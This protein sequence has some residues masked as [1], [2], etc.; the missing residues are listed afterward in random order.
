MA[1]ITAREWKSGNMSG[2]AACSTTEPSPQQVF[3]LRGGAK[4]DT[5]G[6]S[7][8]WTRATPRPSS[9]HA[10]PTYGQWRAHQRAREQCA[11]PGIQP[12]TVA[13]ARKPFQRPVF[14]RP[15]PAFKQPSPRQHRSPPTS[16]SQARW[17]HPRQG[18]DV[19][20]IGRPLD[21]RKL[22]KMLLEAG[23]DISERNVANILHDAHVRKDTRGPSLNAPQF[24]SELM[25]MQTVDVPVQKR[26]AASEFDLPF[27]VPYRV[28]LAFDAVDRDKSGYL[29][30][31][32]I[33][34]ALK[35]YGIDATC[36]EAAGQV[37]EA[38]G[39]DGQLDFREF[40]LLVAE[41]EEK[42]RLHRQLSHFDASLTPRQPFS[43]R[44][45]RDGVGV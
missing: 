26:D 12:S 15:P 32:E 11:Q 36:G 23:I 37:R 38:A 42:K 45:L 10:T 30:E 28:R 3:V 24:F 31:D 41:L 7:V 9:Y 35:R 40:A 1:T 29:D 17:A 8:L 2:W 16:Y 14:H 6:H 44:I 18:L 5:S 25:R 43:P 19:D 21:P 13:Y 27:E 39:A 22:R 34:A 4:K 33:V 20:D